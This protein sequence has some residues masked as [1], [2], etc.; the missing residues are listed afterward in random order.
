MWIWFDTKLMPIGKL[1]GNGRT[2]SQEAKAHFALRT[3]GCRK[4]ANLFER[5]RRKTRELKSK[6][7]CKFYK[8][9]GYA[10]PA[11]G[12]FYI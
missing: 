4:K 11:T 7:F 8:N 9:E 10:S 5:E 3:T 12:Y 1:S 2:Q 6:N